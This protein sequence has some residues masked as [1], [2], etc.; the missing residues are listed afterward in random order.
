MIIQGRQLNCY[1]CQNI[2][3]TNF[4]AVLDVS[5][6]V[7]E[8]GSIGW[9]LDTQVTET[10]ITDCSIKL[11]DNPGDTIYSW[12]QANT[13]SA[14]GVLPPFLIITLSVAING[15]TPAWLTN[16]NYVLFQ[17]VQNLNNTYVCST[18]GISANSGGP[19]GN[20]FGIADG[21]CK[22]DFVSPVKFYGVIDPRYIQT[23]TD[24]NQISIAAHSWFQMTSL[25]MLYSTDANGNATSW[26]RQ[27]IP[28]YSNRPQ[29]TDVGN[30]LQTSS[31]FIQQS[32]GS[33]YV[34]GKDGSGG[35]GGGK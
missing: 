28:I 13:G 11:F 2:D 5:N 16:T 26:S 34:G 33:G 1:L 18:A 23:D 27:P 24:S 14:E 10:T 25:E 3:G 6:N 21:T 8:I 31:Q 4:G 19:S 32:G 30:S 29:T 12:I 22:W 9:A 7:I 20:L 35:G 15:S 17:E